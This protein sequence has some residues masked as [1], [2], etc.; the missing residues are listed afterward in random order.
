MDAANA[1]FTVEKFVG[2]TVGGIGESRDGCREEHG[3]A[4]GG[5]AALRHAQPGLV[6]YSRLGTLHLQRSICSLAAPSAPV[7]S[8]PPPESAADRASPSEIRR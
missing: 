3:S 6:S 5:L 8:A 1:T 4:F 2:Q 7:S